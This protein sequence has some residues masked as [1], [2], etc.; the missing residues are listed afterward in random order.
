VVNEVRRDWIR[1]SYTPIALLHI[2]SSSV[3]LGLK[4]LRGVYLGL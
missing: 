1:D 3:L 2:V 4:R